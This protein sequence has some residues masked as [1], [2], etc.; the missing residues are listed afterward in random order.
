MSESE[1]VEL[2]VVH[3]NAGKNF[4]TAR[5]PSEPHGSQNGFFFRGEDI[6]TLGEETLK[7]GSRIRARLIPDLK[8]LGHSRATDIEIYARD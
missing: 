1:F 5:H 2:V 3:W 6:Q 8:K 7:P 4:G